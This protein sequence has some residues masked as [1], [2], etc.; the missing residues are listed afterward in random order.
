LR[1]ALKQNGF[2]RLAFI[3]ASEAIVLVM[4]LS[5]EPLLM[6]DSDGIRFAMEAKANVIRTPGVLFTSR[7]R[8]VSSRRFARRSTI[9]G[10]PGSGSATSTTV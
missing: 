2:V 6:D 8:E 9:C 3:R 5:S 1:T 10:E 4:E 7:N